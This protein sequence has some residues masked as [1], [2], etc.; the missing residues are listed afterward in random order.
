[1]TSGLYH[2]TMRREETLFSHPGIFPVDDPIAMSVKATAA[3][4][5]S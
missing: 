2:P 3:T 4:R 1:V 5:G